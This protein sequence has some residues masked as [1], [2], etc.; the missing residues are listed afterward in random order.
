MG[1]DLLAEPDSL[2]VLRSGGVWEANQRRC[3][4]GHGSNQ[5]VREASVYN[6]GRLCVVNLVRIRLSVFQKKQLIWPGW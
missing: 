4:T 2:A 3:A 1:L 5:N 6:V